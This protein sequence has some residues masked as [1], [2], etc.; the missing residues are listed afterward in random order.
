MMFLAMI[1]A[2]V[3]I[4]TWGAGNPVQHDGWFIRLQSFVRGLGFPPAAGFVIYIAVPVFV[5]QWILGALEPLLFGLIWIA[6][7]AAVLL[8]S[9]G[10]RAFDTLADRYRS[11]CLSGDFEG[12]SFYAQ[13]ELDMDVKDQEFDSAQG[14][15]SEILR[16]LVYLGYQRWFAVLFYFVVFG[17]A[18]AL[19]YR[20][21]QLSRQSPE[22]AM[23]VR[24]LY[25]ADWVP[26]RLLAAVFALTGDFLGARDP[27]VS[28]MSA[29][30][31]AADNALFAVAR[32]AIGTS[33]IND[34]GT[35]ASFSEIAAREV[36]DLQ[37]LMSRSAGAW[38]VAISLLVLYL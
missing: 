26:A 18:G 7:A 23:A 28:C 24:L 36:T 5:A 10:R 37:A 33:G 6:G 34:A 2:L 4:L 22:R 8:Y 16:E 30:A 20:L 38:L 12:A 9:F 19:L 13:S 11:Y 15:H 35:Q 29:P 1:V 21:L 3:L 27:L 25:Y 31:Q 14:V 32:A 17:P